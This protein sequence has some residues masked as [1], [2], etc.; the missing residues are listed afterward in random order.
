MKPHWLDTIKAGD[1]ILFKSGALRTVLKCSFRNDYGLGRRLAGACFPILHCSWTER[2]YTVY[3][4]S[5]LVP[6]VD[7]L[8]VAKINLSK[9]PTAL[10]LLKD[11]SG[12]GGPVTGKAPNYRRV[13]GSSCCDVIGAFS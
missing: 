7:C 13:R 5:D 6:V 12:R 11:L 9:Y 1:V 2:G 10:R 4:R 3:C 8:T